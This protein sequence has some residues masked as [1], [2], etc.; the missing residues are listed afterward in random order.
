[1]CYLTSI[2]IK[3]KHEH[4]LVKE[5]NTRKI[6]QSSRKHWALCFVPSKLSNV[7]IKRGFSGFAVLS[8]RKSEQ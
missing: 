8:F 5:R 3:E 7:K 1:M 4:I 2:K 6:S